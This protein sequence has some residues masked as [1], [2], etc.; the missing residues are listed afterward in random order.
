M[1][2]EL[3]KTLKAGD[4]VSFADGRE[5]TFLMSSPSE[6]DD[7]FIIVSSRNTDIMVNSEELRNV[8]RSNP[9]NTDDNKSRSDTILFNGT[10]YQIIGIEHI[11]TDS[12]FYV[13]VK[14]L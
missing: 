6:M 8:I 13:N 4:I 14:K 12:L 10:K 7:K 1:K 5:F 3:V 11:V 2:I 9:K